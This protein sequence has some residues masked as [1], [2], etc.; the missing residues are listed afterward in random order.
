MA[1]TASAS[2]EDNVAVDS[3]QL[4]EEGSINKSLLSVLSSMQEN[5]V[6]SNSMLCDLVNRK[7]KSSETVPTSKRAKLD[8]KESSHRIEPQHDCSPLW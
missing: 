5:L 7:R 2:N 3:P 8:S 4:H 6:S 1:D